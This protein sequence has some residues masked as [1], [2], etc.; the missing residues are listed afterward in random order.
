M[1]VSR[2]SVQENIENAFNLSL[3]F[4]LKRESLSPYSYAFGYSESF[5]STLIQEI[6]LTPKQLEVLSNKIQE[7]KEYLNSTEAMD[8]S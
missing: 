3:Q 5:I 1:R 6:G 4:A 8:I 2:S 7:R